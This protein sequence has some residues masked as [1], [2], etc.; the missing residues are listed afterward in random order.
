[1]SSAPVAT[2]ACQRSGGASPASERGGRGVPARADGSSERAMSHATRS[3]TPAAPITLA[4]ALAQRKRP[5]G[6]RAPHPPPG[7]RAHSM[8]A[9]FWLSRQLHAHRSRAGDRALLTRGEARA[10]GREAGVELWP[11]SRS[12]AAYAGAVGT[13]DEDVVQVGGAVG[14]RP[15]GRRRRRRMVDQGQCSGGDQPADGADGNDRFHIV[16]LGGCARE[17]LRRC[18]GRS[19]AGDRRASVSRS[20]E[21]GVDHP[22]VGLPRC[23]HR[24]RR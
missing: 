4:R 22:Y 11:R 3:G 23:R 21:L 18:A 12:E 5:R 16:A 6:R 15:L 8:G 1:V 2:P 7:R 19:V 24:G 20:G 9:P 14:D 17:R 13:S 10:V